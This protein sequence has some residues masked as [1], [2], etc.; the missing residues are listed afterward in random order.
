MEHDWILKVYTSG[1]GQIDLPCDSETAAHD[2]AKQALAD[3]GIMYIDGK[4]Q[5]VYCP[6]TSIFQMK[7]IKV[8][9]ESE[10]EAPKA[11]EP[12][13]DEN[14]VTDETTAEVTTGDENPPAE[15]DPGDTEPSDPRS[16]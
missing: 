4:D 7:V 6:M 13:A 2:K 15:D 3:G 8:E 12:T 11:T 1:T 9:R 16:E 10:P 5:A 14:P